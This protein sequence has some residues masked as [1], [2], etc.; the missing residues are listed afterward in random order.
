MPPRS[1]PR[2]RGSRRRS[3]PA[4]PRWS[5]RHRATAITPIQPQLVYVPYYDPLVVYGPWWGPTYQPVV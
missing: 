1:W 3:R 5:S 4:A 2:R